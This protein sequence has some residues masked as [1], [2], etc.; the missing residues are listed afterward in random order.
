MENKNSDIA[1]DHEQQEK[2]DQDIKQL[3]TEL[4]GFK[5]DIAQNLYQLSMTE[6]NER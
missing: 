4:L 1:Y 6:E 5:R 2:F 3:N